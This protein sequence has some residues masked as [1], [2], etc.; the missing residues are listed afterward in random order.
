MFWWITASDG[1]RAVRLRF[2]LAFLATTGVRICFAR[3]VFFF[4]MSCTSSS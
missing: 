4:G 1:R 3:F 2:R